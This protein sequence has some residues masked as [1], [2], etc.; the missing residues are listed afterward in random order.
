MRKSL[1]YLCMSVGA[2]M[3]MLVVVI[4][5]A[6][7]KQTSAKCAVAAPGQKGK[8]VQFE[9]VTTDEARERGL[10]GRPT[11][12]DDQGMAFGFATP[13]RYCVWMKDMKFSLDVVWLNQDQKII[14]IMR[15]V[16]P[17]TYPTSFCPSSNAQ[18]ILELAGGVANQ[19][20]LKVGQK[21]NLDATTP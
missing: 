3:L 12:P 7:P 5:L 1:V 15:Q 20:H 11:L 17:N 16:S 21:L 2:V 13:G 18:Y 9:W 14:K 10:S 4:W 19:V 6:W 8:C